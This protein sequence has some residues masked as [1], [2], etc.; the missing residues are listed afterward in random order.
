MD[1]STSDQHIKSIYKYHNCLNDSHIFYSCFQH[2]KVN[3]E[4][5]SNVKPSPLDSTLPQTTPHA[6]NSPTLEFASP[7]SVTPK[8][9]CNVENTLSLVDHSSPPSV[10][11][12][13]FHDSLPIITSSLMNFIEYF[14]SQGIIV[15][16]LS[17]AP[18]PATYY[19]LTFHEHAL[20]FLVSRPNACFTDLSLNINIGPIFQPDD[21]LS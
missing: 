7:E 12:K 19:T 1:T 20:A 13:S 16:P 15:S 3:K 9:L 10:N 14:H 2:H 11:S 5:E 17:Q 18:S 6:L 4:P 8:C 21:M